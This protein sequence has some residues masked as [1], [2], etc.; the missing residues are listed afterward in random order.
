MTELKHAHRRAKFLDAAAK[1]HAPPAIL[2]KE[3]SGLREMTAVALLSDLHVE[4]PVDPKSVAGRNEYNLEIADRRLKRFFDGFIWNVQHH[5]ASKKVA[6]R[7]GVLWCGGDFMSGFIHE[8]LVQSNALSPT[9]TMLWLLPR[10]RNG[11]THVL[12]SL[13]LDRL[14]IPC[15]YGNHGRTTPKTRIQNGASN[16]YEYMMYNVL[17]AEFKALGEKRVVFEITP[18]PHQYVDVYG[19]TLHFHH[20]DSV[21]YMG[22]VGGLSVPLLKAIAPWDQIKRADYHHIGHFHQITDLGRVLVNGS[23]IGYG[24]YSQW[25]RASFEQP[26]QMFYLLDSK[27]GK[28][29]VAP[30]WVG[31]SV[32]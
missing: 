23:L 31:E 25:I 15:S 21:R 22:G 3:K 24:P 7:T 14:V 28:T 18:S 9:E 8:D 4:E 27:R 16:S 10:L 26:A 12:N 30:I 5:R 29:F 6:I 13:G 32:S 11:I 1:I 19:F 20:G 2:A 17:A